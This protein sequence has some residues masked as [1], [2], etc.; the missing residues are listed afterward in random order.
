MASGHLMRIGK[1]KGGGSVLAAI[2]HNKRFTKHER[3]GTHH[4]DTSRSHL[5]YALVGNCSPKE[6]A[7]LAKAQM[8]KAGIDK[9]RAN[10]V[11]AIEII[12]SLPI[13]RHQQ[14][15]KLFFVDCCCWV[16]NNFAG[17]LL[18][19]DVHL[20][21]SAPHAHALILP[22]V[23]G[24]MQGSDMVGKRSNLYRLHNL[25]HDEVGI[26]HGLKRS[27]RTKLTE[28]DKSNL[29][30]LIVA[31][32]EDNPKK[33]WAV[34]RDWILKDPLPLAELLS[35]EIPKQKQVKHFVDIARSKGKGTF[36]R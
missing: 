24:K 35:I 8:K 23:N 4:I 29:A 2:N 10:A 25:F 18:S 9:P 34:F 21:E 28:E 20:D 14:D 36:I 1:V 15:T 11:L 30:K 17:E 22:L 13:E 32:L 5:N 19:F 7:D 12:F 16:R 27:S 6:I 26:R 31:E 33:G 3:K